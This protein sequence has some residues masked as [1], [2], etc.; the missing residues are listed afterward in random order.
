MLLRFAELLDALCV[1][2]QHNAQV[3]MALAGTRIGLV[4]WKAAIVDSQA[5]L[6]R[7]GLE[8]GVRQAGEGLSAA[9]QTMLAVAKALFNNARLIILDE[10]TAALARGDIDL[11]FSLVRAQQ[12]QGLAFIY[13]PT[14]SKKSS[15]SATVSQLCAVTRLSVRE[16]LAR[17][18]CRS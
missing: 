3:R 13:I 17:S 4:D 1:R 6:A 15:R 11:L 16:R 12:E 18:M 5:R 8:L 10:P 9:G 2:Y 14:T 7:L